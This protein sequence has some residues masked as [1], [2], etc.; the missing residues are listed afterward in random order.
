M[1][2]YKKNFLTFFCLF[3]LLI[4]VR[5][6]YRS[7]GFIYGSIY[8][9][10]SYPPCPHITY[11]VQILL[12]LIGIMLLYFSF[13]LWKEKSWKELML[14]A[15]ILCLLIS[16]YIFVISGDS[17]WYTIHQKEY[18]LEIEE[19]VPAYYE[20]F[21]Y[22]MIIVFIVIGVIT[23]ILSLKLY[24]AKK[25]EFF[26]LE[27]ISSFI[28]SILFLYGI[29]IV[30]M[31]IFLLDFHFKSPPDYYSPSILYIAFRLIFGLSLILLLPTQKIKR[32]I[33]IPLIGA[34]TFHGL[35][36]ISHEVS[37]A[38]EGFWGY[39]ISSNFI[40]HLISIFIGIVSIILA[41]VILN[42]SIEEIKDVLTERYKI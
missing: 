14:S 9:P 6:I 37:L 1:K 17:L 28:S 32:S 25:K 12:L 20:I 8:P 38:I 29:T 27:S 22:I 42:L 16:F 21:Q 35:S 41:F 40:L 2:V 18:L 30:C 7:C 31:S 5:Y 11:L 15:F 13:K 33:R 3:L 10:I 23:M 36:I 39:Q 4:G 26:Y 24:R 34:F 19:W